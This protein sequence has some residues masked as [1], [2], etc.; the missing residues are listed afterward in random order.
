MMTLKDL[1]GRILL[2]EDNPITQKMMGSML[3]QWGHQVILV[4]DGIE[5]LEQ[6]KKSDFDVLIL[7]YQMPRMDGLETY[8]AL[9]ELADPA[10][11]KMPV[12]LLTAEINPIVLKEIQDSGIKY[13]MR[14]P[15]QPKVFSAT[16]DQLLRKNKASGR[17]G[18]ASTEYLR[19]IT[20][21][22]QVLMSEIIDLFIEE[23]P[24]NIQ[25]MKSYCLVE[26]WV[27]L[28]RMIHKVKANF[29][30]VGMERQEDIIKRFEIDLE[31]LAFPE[32][33]LSRII[34]IEKITEEAI[35][36]LKKKKKY[37]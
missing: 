27:N 21:T 25:R 33:Y 32:T 8:K 4:S 18:T 1:S 10:I 17:K 30:Y 9:Q 35:E 20:D 7:D 15:V 34:Q 26:D 5:V 12:M 6:L 28:K 19:K 11:S 13:Y 23:A 37:S 24:K 29:A 16:L 14:K 22:N 3:S 36:T 31:G 2:A